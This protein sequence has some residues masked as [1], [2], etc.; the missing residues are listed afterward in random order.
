MAQFM[1]VS[2]YPMS[3]TQLGGII[4]HCYGPF[5]EQEA[6]S[7]IEDY[8]GRFNKVA[9]Y[10]VHGISKKSLEKIKLGE[11]KSGLQLAEAVIKQAE[12]YVTKN[13]R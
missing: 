6:D 5:S 2:S 3:N 10:R 8:K 1:I 13:S 9:N 4:S 12:D 7:F 11:E